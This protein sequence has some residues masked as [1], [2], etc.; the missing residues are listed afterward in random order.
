MGM[1][2]SASLGVDETEDI[3]VTN[4]LDWCF[5]VEIWLS[6]VGVEPPLV[7]SILMMV[8]SNLLLSRTFGIGLNVRMEK[9]TTITH[10]L[11]RSS[12]SI[13]DFE[14]AVLSHLSTSKVGLEQGAHLG[15]SRATVLQNGEVRSEGEHVYD[16]RHY[17]QACNS[18]P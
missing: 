4:I 9:S 2:I 8:A 17:N 1:E 10:I 18:C 3:P 14:R 15:I 16:Q 12:R 13:G 6:T 7:V 5:G 11:N